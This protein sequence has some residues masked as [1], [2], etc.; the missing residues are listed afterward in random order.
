MVMVYLLWFTITLVQ[1][2]YFTSF[3]VKCMKSRFFESSIV[4]MP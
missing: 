2:G 4:L 1:F 3:I